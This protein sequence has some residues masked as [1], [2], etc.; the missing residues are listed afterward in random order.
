M[1]RALCLALC[2]L[3]NDLLTNS[4]IRCIFM[5]I[6][7][8]LTLFVAS[9]TLKLIERQKL[10][11]RNMVVIIVHEEDHQTED[12]D[13]IQGVTDKL[14]VGVE[15]AIEGST[16]IVEKTRTAIIVGREEVVLDQNPDPDPVQDYEETVQVRGEGHIIPGRDHVPDPEEMD[17]S[18]GHDRKGHVRGPK[19]TTEEDL[20]DQDLGQAQA[21]DLVQDQDLDHLR[22]EEIDIQ[23]QRNWEFSEYT[24]TSFLALTFAL[25]QACH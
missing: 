7:L 21:Q 23:Y 14:E 9:F 11:K 2:A 20:I 25:D 4:Y 22:K 6:D 1:F 15:I 13:L 10:I 3:V 17:Q 12:V 16:L 19:T 5:Y 24:V 8:F 18:P